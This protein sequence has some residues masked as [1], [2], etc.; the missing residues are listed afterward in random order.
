MDEKTGTLYGTFKA[1]NP[2]DEIAAHVFES[3]ERLF[4][5]ELDPPEALVDFPFGARTR[6]EAREALAQNVA[7]FLPRF[8]SQV[9]V[10]SASRV[11]IRE[12]GQPYMHVDFRNGAVRARIRSGIDDLSKKAMS[13][14]YDD[15]DTVLT[16]ANSIKAVTKSDV[17]NIFAEYSDTVIEHVPDV[18]RR[19][20][21]ARFM[22]ALAGHLHAAARGSNP[23]RHVSGAIVQLYAVTSDPDEAEGEALL[24]ALRA[25]D[26]H[27]RMNNLRVDG[28]GRVSLL[29]IAICR[30]YASMGYVI[31]G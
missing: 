23:P 6:H 18:I 29:D 5:N 12:D 19:D 4:L 7:R 28:F 20:A 10:T 30:T 21:F 17:C 1:E 2:D 8:F 27:F 31:G 24:E 11:C 3:A 25:I 9:I 14:D 15:V 13:F 16:F 26:R 22:N